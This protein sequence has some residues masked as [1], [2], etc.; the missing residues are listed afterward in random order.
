MP[1]IEK[2]VFFRTVS[3][4]IMAIGF[5]MSGWTIPTYYDSSGI[6]VH[7]FFKNGRG[8]YILRY[9]HKFSG[10]L[11]IPHGCEL[12]F[13][14]GRLIGDIVFDATKLSEQVD[15]RGSH[16][17]GS[18][19]NKTFNAAWLCAKDGVSDDAPRINEMITVC[20][21]LIFPKG[22]YRLVS[23]Y[24]KEQFHI[25]I[26][27]NNVSLTGEEG[28][29]FL[30]KERLGMIC[31]LSKPYDIANSVRN[32]SIKNITFRTINDGSVFLEWTH[33]IQSKGVNG[34]IIEHCTIE[35]FWGDGIC[36]NHYGDTPKT[37]ERTRNQNV[38]IIN[39]TII[40]GKKHNNRNGISVINGKNVL[41]K[42]NVIRNTSRKDMP[43]AIDVEPN[44]SAYTI[45]NIKIV[46]NKIS[47]SRGN[48]GAIEICMFNGGPGHHI[49]VEDN[50]IS[51]S[52]LGF[53]ICVQTN[54]TTSDIVIRNNRVAADTPPYKF[55]GNGVSKNWIISG[56]R[57]EQRTTLRIPG[58]LRI[59][60]LQVK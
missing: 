29:V 44:N 24:H 42:G 3:L 51:N 19:T 14:G 43:G 12:S 27:K 58:N 56:N 60:N 28:T 9:T 30:T 57:F 39:N 53:Y 7:Q 21:N 10:T 8:I 4:I 23:P 38:K 35:D 5:S 6:N 32:V 52:N 18:V 46:G 13:K 50:V 37:G 45:D 17:K 34:F 15:L 25:A 41:I 20:G 40:G 59:K 2:S 48:C 54:N 11:Q 47:G 1:S 55:V 33:A 16:I 36:M 26:R 31:V 49:Y 22:I